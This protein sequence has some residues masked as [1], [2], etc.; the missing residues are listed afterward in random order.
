[1]NHSRVMCRPWP[2]WPPSAR[3]AAIIITAAL[4]VPAA[5]CSGS[6]SA[7]GSGGSAER[8]ST[9]P[10]SAVAYSACVR[11]HGVPNFPDPDS[12]GNLP[13]G[14]AQHFGASTS[15]FQAARTVCQH[16]LP[17]DGGAINASSISQCMMAGDCPR[18]LVQQVLTEERNFAQCMRSDGVPTWPDPSIDSQGRPVF[19]ISISKLGFDPY[20]TQVWAK[21][22]Q[23][24]HL[25]PGLPGLPAAVSP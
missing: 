5:G 25:M 23:C 12:S 1:M 19:A 16:L 14:D 15:Q 13:K 2:A 6:P 9:R 21:G 24:S 3:A 22:N 18:V 20:S 4:A 8:R 10:P 7:A 17:N 11:S